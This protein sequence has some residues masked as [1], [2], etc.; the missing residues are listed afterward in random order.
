MWLIAGMLYGTG[1]RLLEDLRLRIKDV[2]FERREIIIRDG[3]GAKDRVTVLP[4][5]I[6]LPLKKQMEKAKL[7]H[8]TDND[9]NT[10]MIYTHVL[11][12]GGRG[13]ISPL[14]M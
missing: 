10:T 12:K 8:D 5:N 3:K 1:M 14:D 6:L 9:V 13:I 11:N 2:E 7:L 4:E